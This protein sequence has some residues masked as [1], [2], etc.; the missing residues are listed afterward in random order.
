MDETRL[1]YILT[2]SYKAEMISYLKS[3]PEDF[4]EA[5]ELALSDKPP[6]S[7]RAAW[8]LWSCMDDN[9]K[10]VTPYLDRIVEM[11]ISVGDNQQRELIIILQRMN[12]PDGIQ[13]KLFDH[14]ANIWKKIGNQ[15]SFRYNAFKLMAK[16]TKNHPDLSTEL[17]IWTE[18]HFMDNM[19]NT[20]KKSIT[21]IIERMK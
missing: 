17:V 14:C 2:H 20:A 5:I 19:S 10:R 18:S 11:L 1:E 16:I 9:D 13:G 7:W 21:R 4:E 8:L 15:P 6:Y 12:L 3:H